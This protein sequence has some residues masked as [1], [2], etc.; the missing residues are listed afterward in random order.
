MNGERNVGFGQ[1]DQL[2]VVTADDIRQAVVATMIEFKAYIG[3][4]DIG[5]N[6]QRFVK[7]CCIAVKIGKM[8]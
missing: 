4:D 2:F 6:H 5:V 3:K 1:E 8:G 7:S